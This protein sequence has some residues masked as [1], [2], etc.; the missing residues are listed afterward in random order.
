MTYDQKRDIL[1]LLDRFEMTAQESEG[2]TPSEVHAG[3]A[4]WARADKNM[5]LERNAKIVRRGQTL[6]ADTVMM[7]LTPDE[8]HVQMIQLQGN[9]RISGEPA[10]GAAGGEGGGSTLRGMHARDINLTYGQDGEKLQQA[11]LA[12]GSSVEV[13]SNAGSITRIAGEFIDFGLEADGTTMRSL[14]ARGANPA[15]RAELRLPAQAD[16]PARVIRAVAIQGPTPGTVSEP[17]RGLTSLRFA[18]NVEYRE[19]PAPPAS[20]RIASAR[21]LD[22]TMQPGFGAVDEARFSGNATLKEGT[23]LEAAARDARYDVK[24]GTFDFTGT[25]DEGRPPQVKD[26]QQATIQANRIVVTPE[27]RKVSASG[28]VQTTLQAAQ[29]GAGGTTVHTPGILDQDRPVYARSDELEYDG[30]ASQAAFKSKVQ[31]RLWQSQGGTAISGVEIA[32]DDAKGDLRARG[33]VVSTMMLEQVDDKTKRKERVSTTVKADELFYEDA[34]HRATYTGHVQM[35]GGVQGTL[36]TDKVILNL[37][38]DGRALETLEAFANVELHDD[39][40]PTTG[41]RTA[42]GDHLT[43][44]A[45][46]GRYKITGRLVKINEECFGETQGRTLTFYRSID[47]M[48]VDGNRERRTQTKGG[49]GCKKESRF[50]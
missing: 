47:R 21:V 14:S 24:R 46:D 43:Y 22:L 23:S 42:T 35:T 44:T 48:I 34:V 41:K 6:E 25:D 30:A 2:Q 9:S 28:A 26:Q 17:G 29:K 16:A 38:Q 13:C 27:G 5:R 20:P 18:E 39:G 7:Y 33:S 49:Q 12:G 32:L 3:T 36:K 37:T 40:T 15:S 50:D 1:S 31:S 19:M 8:Q 11:V 4:V 45:A 10:T